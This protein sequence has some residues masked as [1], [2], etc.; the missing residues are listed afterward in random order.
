ME[1]EQRGEPRPDR[2]C[3]PSWL[4]VRHLFTATADTNAETNARVLHVLNALR[5]INATATAVLDARNDA[6]WSSVA[7]ASSSSSFPPPRLPL[8]L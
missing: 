1:C 7:P 4:L 8:S 2:F 3:P 6:E 5:T